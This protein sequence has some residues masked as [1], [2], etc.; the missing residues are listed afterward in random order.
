M[1][2]WHGGVCEGSQTL[3]CICQGGEKIFEG[4]KGR[5][6]EEERKN[7]AMKDRRVVFIFQSKSDK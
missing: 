3:C 7:F 2:T 4:R 1:K 5:G 6:G